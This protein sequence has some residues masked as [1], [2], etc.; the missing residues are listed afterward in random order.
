M[1]CKNIPNWSQSQMMGGVRYLRAAILLPPRGFYFSVCILSNNTHHLP[2]HKSA[3]P[4]AHSRTTPSPL[5]MR[6]A[7]PHRAH[8]LDLSFIFSFHF[9][10][11]PFTFPP[12][13]HPTTS[14]F[15]SAPSLLPS[16]FHL[17][18]LPSVLQSLHF[19]SS[20]PFSFLLFSYPLPPCLFSSLLWEQLSHTSQHCPASP[21]WTGL[22]FRKDGQCPQ[23]LPSDKIN[24][25]D[26]VFWNIV[27]HRH[28]T[29]SP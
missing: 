8:S 4:P 25:S 10:L 3:P 29:K 5:F 20:H 26:L 27:A 1:Y 21:V 2:Q 15:L 7:G 16:S 9:H 14:S 12:C 17:S 23:L 18:F 19:F 28:L 22:E 11:F 24:H 13:F 6:I